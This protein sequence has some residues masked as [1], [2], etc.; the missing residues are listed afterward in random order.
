MTEKTRAERIEDQE[1]EENY[2]AA[3]ELETLAADLKR[4]AYALREVSDLKRNLRLMEKKY[5]DLLR[6][7]I[8]HG[9]VMA[10]NLLTLALRGNFTRNETADTKPKGD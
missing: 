1:E 8:R 9:E 4:G 6:D 3:L 2:R 7:S 10:G 5:N